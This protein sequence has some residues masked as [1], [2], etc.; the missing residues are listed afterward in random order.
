M[1][2]HASHFGVAS[3]GLPP[4]GVPP[5]GLSHVDEGEVEPRR[6]A[7]GRLGESKQDGIEGVG[8]APSSQNEVENTS[9]LSHSAKRRNTQVGLVFRYREQLLYFSFIGCVCTGCVVS[10]NRID[11]SYEIGS[12]PKGL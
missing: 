10:P 2:G 9:A 6:S 7:T 5:E 4:E 12:S 8:S 1:S 3:P 11:G